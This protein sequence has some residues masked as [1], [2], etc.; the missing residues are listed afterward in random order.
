MAQ[1]LTTSG[2]LWQQKASRSVKSVL[3]LLGQSGF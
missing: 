1:K 2:T 3:W